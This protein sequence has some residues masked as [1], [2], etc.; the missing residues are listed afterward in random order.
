M[1]FEKYT[2]RSK[3]FVQAAQTLAQRRGNQ[4]IT[5]EH[6][7]KV[8]LDDKEG[9]ASN[10]IRAAQGDPVAVHAAVD[11]ALDKLPRIEGAGAGQVYLS[12][13]TARDSFVTVE[14]LLLALTLLKESAA[15]KALASAGITPQNLNRAI[16]DIRKGRRADNASAEEGY[17]ALKK[18]ARDLTAVA[19]EGKLDPVIGRD[20][21]IRRTVQ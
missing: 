21:E 8:L 11:G 19:R 6:I 17:D 16:E 18:Y 2:E 12:P 3:G 1:N 7:L 10:L 4:Q 14:R 5:P 20:E 13:E 15:A 9:L